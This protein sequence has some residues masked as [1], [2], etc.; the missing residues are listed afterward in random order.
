MVVGKENKLNKI[1]IP[2]K[3]IEIFSLKEIL[4]FQI[5]SGTELYQ[6][7]LDKINSLDDSRKENF[8]VPQI[9]EKWKQDLDDPSTSEKNFYLH[10]ME[11]LVSSGTYIR[12]LVHKW[13]KTWVVVL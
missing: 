7:I 4:P 10:K 3:E 2:S 6:Q 1:T 11:A 5:L 9:L 13:V 8:R 12:S